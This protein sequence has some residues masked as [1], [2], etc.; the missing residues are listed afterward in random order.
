M[1]TKKTL[2]ELLSEEG[3]SDLLKVKPKQSKSSDADARARAQFEEINVFFDRYGHA[4]GQGA[5]GR[6]IGVMERTYQAR[7]RAYAEDPALRAA[8]AGLDRHGLLP[9]IQEEVHLASLEDILASG[10]PLLDDP[11]EGIFDLVHAKAA[12][13]KPEMI[14]ER[15]PCEDF[16]QFKPIFDKAAS[17]LASG[18][19][20]SMRFANEQ[21]IEAGGFFILNGVMVYVAEVRDP[22]VRNGKR[23]ARLRLIFDNGTE[24][25]NL[26][27]SLATE[28]YKDPNGRRISDPNPGPLFGSAPI[29]QTQ[30]EQP[31]DRITGLI[32]VVR[33]L[34]KLPEIARLD[35]NLFKIGFTTGS[36]EARLRG[37]E[38][39][40]TFLLAPVK[41]VMTY[42]AVNI[43]ANAFERLVHHFF[44]EAR[45]NIEIKDRFGK[46]IKPREWFLLPFPI[47]E[48]AIPL[49]IDGSILRYRYDHRA[50]AIVEAR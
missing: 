1:A 50:C 16:E 37:A 36:L 47:I 7:L 27:R 42:Q 6:K 48:Q 11:N 13:A 31:H 25:Q 12:P 43:N 49:M 15:V 38:D 34:S 45:L 21:E 9:A 10:D 18:A 39:D 19:R 20:R 17:E 40:P 46:A 26:L 33:S 2:D 4:P 35:G 29:A 5:D 30:A 3:D 41:P 24:G 44:D 14:S 23:N 28:L 22:H 8:V 32:Y